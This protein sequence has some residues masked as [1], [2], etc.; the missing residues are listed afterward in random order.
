MHQQAQNK[1]YD[2]V[3]E[4]LVKLVREQYQIRF[5]LVFSAIVG[6][7]DELF[8]TI[9]AKITLLPTT[10]AI[11]GYILRS[12]MGTYHYFHYIFRSIIFKVRR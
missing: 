2:I 12:T 5:V 11:F 9:F 4:S 8:L 7:I 10:V 1:K 6:I 3:L